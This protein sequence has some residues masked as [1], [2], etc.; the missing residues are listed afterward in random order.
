MA[1]LFNFGKQLLDFGNLQYV[2]ISNFNND[3]QGI[4]VN[5]HISKI[6]KE[7][8]SKQNIRVPLS[9]ISVIK[10]GFGNRKKGIQFMKN[11]I[12]AWES[13]LNSVA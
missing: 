4:Y 5:I 7:Y 8:A 9:K 10:I 12:D 1:H 2:D 3:H 6:K 13:Y 11:L